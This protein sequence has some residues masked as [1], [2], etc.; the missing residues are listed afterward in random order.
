VATVTNLA[1]LSLSETTDLLVGVF[2]KGF[3]SLRLGVGMSLPNYS[4][5][6]NPNACVIKGSQ[7]YVGVAIA[8]HIGVYTYLD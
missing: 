3:E 5:G 8:S 7:K 2:G 6:S 1:S 4:L